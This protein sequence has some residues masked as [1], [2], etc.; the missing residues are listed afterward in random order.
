M[1]VQNR[2]TCQRIR[3]CAGDFPYFLAISPTLGSSRMTGSSGVAQGRSENFKNL[4]KS[5]FLTTSSARFRISVL[6]YNFIIHTRHIIKSYDFKCFQA[7]GLFSVVF[8]WRSEWAV[9]DDDDVVLL[10]EVDHLRLSQVRVALNL[11]RCRLDLKKKFLIG[12]KM[13]FRKCG[14]V[15]LGKKFPRI[16]ETNPH[17]NEYLIRILQP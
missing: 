3:I 5:D 10:A 4:F 14:L 17:L 6:Y 16:R 2:P 12:L 9:S 8:T 13:S 15:L 1:I 7:F 11:V